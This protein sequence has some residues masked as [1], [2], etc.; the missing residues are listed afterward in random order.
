MKNK[1]SIRKV[2][3]DMSKTKRKLQ[4]NKRIEKTLPKGHLTSNKRNST[5]KKPERK[6]KLNSGKIPKK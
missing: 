2:S 4:N 1:S 6:K 3:S 5:M